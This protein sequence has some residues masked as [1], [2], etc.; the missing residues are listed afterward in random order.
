MCIEVSIAYLT[1]SCTKGKYSGIES[2]YQ[3]KE[4]KHAY[5]RGR[6]AKSGVDKY[7]T[8]IR[9]WKFG[10]L[11]TNR[12]RVMCDNSMSVTMLGTK[13]TV[14]AGIRISNLA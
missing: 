7:W 4:S 12:N 14:T 8:W 1:N 6:N 11:L 13:K 9:I 5:R 2:V 10:C 3:S